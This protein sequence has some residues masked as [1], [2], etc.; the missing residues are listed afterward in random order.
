MYLTPPK[1]TLKMI[2]M[3]VYFIKI[4]KNGGR[5]GTCKHDLTDAITH[6]FDKTAKGETYVRR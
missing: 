4:K 6:V 3:Y 5:G 2:K 1:S